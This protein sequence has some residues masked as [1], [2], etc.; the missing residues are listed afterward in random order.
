M[1]VYRSLLI[2]RLRGRS[3]L[4]LRHRQLSVVARPQHLA[5]DEPLLKLLYLPAAFERGYLL[6]GRYTVKVG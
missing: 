5:L 2:G 1:V 4:L 6:R 3:H